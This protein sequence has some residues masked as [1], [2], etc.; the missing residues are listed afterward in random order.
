MKGKTLF[1]IVLPFVLA[2][3]MGASFAVSQA[4]GFE[5]WF[6]IGFRRRR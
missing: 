6:G 2:F 4:S 3:F 1:A 5:G